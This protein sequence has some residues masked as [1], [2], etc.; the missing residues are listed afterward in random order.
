M[1]DT[2]A[3]ASRKKRDSSSSPSDMKTGS[4]EDMRACDHDSSVH[5]Q[6]EHEDDS[7][8]TKN[9]IDQDTD[10]Q[11]VQE[12]RDH[13]RNVLL[14]FTYY[15]RHSLVR[16][17]RRRRDY[18]ALPQQHKR[19]VPDLLEKIDRVDRCIEA[20]MEF[21]RDVVQE[22]EAFIG[23]D[24]VQLMTEGYDQR[25]PPVTPGDMD[26]VRSTFR[27][28][29]RDWSVEGKKERDAAYRPILDTL[30]ALYKDVPVEERRNINVL[31]PGAGL[32]RLAFE[33][34]QNGFACQGNEFSFFM[35]IC[36]HFILNRV[37][38]V[39]Q[40]S[41]YPY[42]HSFSNVRDTEHHLK[43]IKVPDVLPSDLP[44]SADFSMAAG[45]FVEIYSRESQ[46]ES[47]D[48]IA[49]CFFIDTAKNIV[50]YLETIYNALKFGGT[51]INIGPLLYHF[52]DMPGESSI[53]LS[54]DQVKRVAREIGFEI[55]EERTVPTTYTTYNDSMLKYLYESEFWVATKV[56]KK[57]NSK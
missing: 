12:E 37:S 16:N 38:H 36:S 24:P 3:S 35:L 45:D 42:I 53:E 57:Q 54:L 47:W 17:Q 28:F 6:N 39:A 5:N 14:S 9:D 10:E 49:T 32:G 51:W 29:V 20:N 25:D 19:L 21:V 1:A 55:K 13:L 40:Y 22:C 18:Q 50:E 15:R 48:V 46:I 2:T 34:A 11:H 23:M 27:Q 26:K 43:P 56:Q 44:P 31:V 8:S 7:N 4:K 41:I 52:E 33:I 30:K